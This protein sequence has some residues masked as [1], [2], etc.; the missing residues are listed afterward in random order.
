MIH[1]NLAIAL[2][3]AG[4]YIGGALALKAA[5]HAG[6]LSHE[7]TVRAVGVFSGLQLAIYANFLPK[8]AGNI[9]NPVT[10]ACMQSVLRVSGWAYTLGGLA[11]AVANLLLVPYPVPAVLLGVATAYALG[12]SAWA[13]M[14]RPPGKPTT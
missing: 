12:Y 1:K 2:V 7:V 5:E 3:A 13:F 10:A 4:T 9:P 8:T 14:E 11:F 6:L